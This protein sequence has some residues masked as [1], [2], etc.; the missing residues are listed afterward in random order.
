M[1]N[2]IKI[3]HEPDLITIDDGP[4]SDRKFGFLFVAIFSL[5]TLW[6]A[7]SRAYWAAIFAALALGTFIAAIWRPA[8]LHVFNIWWYK[9]SILLHRII[10]PVVMGIVF[11]LVVTP[12]AIIMRAMGKDPPSLRFDKSQKSYWISRS[13]ENASSP[14]MKNQF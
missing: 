4:G 5:A 10:S 8:L 9:F 1:G 3:A 6:G 11:F 13:A 7:H 14:S 2:R 12:T